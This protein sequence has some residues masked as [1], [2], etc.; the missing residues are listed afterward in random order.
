[1]SE[2]VVLALGWIGLAAGVVAM[3]LYIVVLLQRPGVTRLL[4]GSGLFFTGL[5]LT[6]AP[7]I[8]R[9]EP[10]SATNTAWAVLFMS[11][12]AALQSLAAIRN[13]R[14][15]DGVERRGNGGAG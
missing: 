1:M 7:F 13:R 10:A 9:P 11:L 4:N 3:V 8:L 2:G 12:A 14:A 15:W 6:Q 5:A